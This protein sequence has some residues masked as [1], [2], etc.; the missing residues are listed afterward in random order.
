MVDT[1]VIIGISNFALCYLTKKFVRN[2]TSG[3]LFSGQITT[4]LNVR[5]QNKSVI[6]IKN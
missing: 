1:A 3:T 4:S 6:A 5:W 2:F